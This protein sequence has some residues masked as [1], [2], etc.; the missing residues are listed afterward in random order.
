MGKS[1]YIY[2]Y[3]YIIYVNI[4]S[5]IARGSPYILQSIYL[6]YTAV[7]THFFH[8][9]VNTMQTIFF[10][11]NLVSE[12]VMGTGTERISRMSSLPSDDADTYQGTRPSR[13]H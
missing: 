1:L 6:K 5:I 10:W 13:V 11:Q 7:I 8:K 4:F 2:L 9:V 3:I 12:F